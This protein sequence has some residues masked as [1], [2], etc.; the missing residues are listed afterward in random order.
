MTSL[1]TAL[2]PS[3]WFKYRSVL[4]T[5]PLIIGQESEGSVVEDC[6]ITFLATSCVAMNLRACD[7][8]HRSGNV[9]KRGG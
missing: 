7:R 3:V 4:Q 6:Q 8:I 2:G 5:K 1:T 9:E